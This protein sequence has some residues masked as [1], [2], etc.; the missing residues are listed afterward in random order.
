MTGIP[1]F[2]QVKLIEIPF[3]SQTFPSQIINLTVRVL[4][5]FLSSWDKPL[6]KATWE[7][8]VYLAYRLQVHGQAG[9]QGKDLEAGTKAK[10]RTKATCWYVLHG[11]LN[12]LFI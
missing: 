10:A 11:L 12:L 4:T 2:L 1:H 9:T 6:A 7:E 8:K 3:H 5:C